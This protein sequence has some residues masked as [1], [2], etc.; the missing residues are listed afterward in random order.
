MALLSL[1]MAPA[2]AA[3]L[4]VLPSFATNVAQCFG[5]HWRRLARIGRAA[6]FAAGR[7]IP[8]AWKMQ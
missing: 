5:P 7:I 1:L 8:P 6:T 4:M 3:M 2:Q